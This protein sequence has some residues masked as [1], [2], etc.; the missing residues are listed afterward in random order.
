MALTANQ[1]NYYQTTF[2]NQQYAVESGAIHIYQG[3]LL[4]FDSS[5]Y[6]VKSSDKTGEKF[7]GVS[8]EELNQATGGSAGD[9][10]I[11]VIPKGSGALVKMKT[12]RIAITDVG[13]K[14][15]ANGDD[16][17]DLAGTTTHDLEVGTI[18]IFIDTTH[19]WVQI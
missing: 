15:Y 17:V 3:A 14:V 11:N 8:L 9:N 1:S 6:I 4:N 10:V 7:A 19:A 5:G 13:N 16:Q 2:S 18:R 12:A